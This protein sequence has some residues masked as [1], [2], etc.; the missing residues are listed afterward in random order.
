MN[1]PPITNHPFISVVIP[2]WNEEKYIRGA[3]EGLE[4]QTYPKGPYEVIVVDNDSADD[5]GRIAEEYGAKLVK[6]KFHGVAHARHTG[7]EVAKGEVFAGTDAD[8]RPASDW[9]EKIAAHFDQDPS[10]VGLTGPAYLSET[11]SLQSKFGYFI[12]D[13]FQ[14]FNFAIGKPT[15]SGFNF[16][17]RRDAY[18]SVGGF[19]I[20]KVSA[21]DVDLSFRLAKVGKVKYFDDVKVFTSAR[22]LK[23]NPLEFLRHNLKN[24][25]SML[26]GR[27]PEPF[28]PIR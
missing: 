20:H 15:F 26:A 10:L 23:K 2:A 22:R 11:G 7:Y 8:S 5:T 3:L 6:D 14:R 19:D 13:K 24:Y 28:E 9:L 21:E 27:Q 17:V 4:N 12:F 16:A 1:Q 25:F 18:K